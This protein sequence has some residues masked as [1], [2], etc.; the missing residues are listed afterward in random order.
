MTPLHHRLPRQA[1]A[2]EVRVEKSGYSSKIL[3]IPQGQD[4]RGSIRLERVAE[5]DPSGGEHIIK[6]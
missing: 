6:L 1:G 2:L 5:P 3:T 4:Y